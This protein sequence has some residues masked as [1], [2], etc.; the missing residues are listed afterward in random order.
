M[1]PDDESGPGQDTSDRTY[2]QPPA[3]MVPQ[4]CRH[5]GYLQRPYRCEPNRFRALSLGFLSCPQ[6]FPCHSGGGRIFG[7]FGIVLKTFGVGRG[8]GNR[9][10]YD[11]NGGGFG[12]LG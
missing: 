6:Y 2:Y 11:R 3:Q 8:L 5:L 10:G 1:N 12:F 4:M 7:A 9:S